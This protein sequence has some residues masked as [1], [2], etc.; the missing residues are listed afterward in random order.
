MAIKIIK[1][2]KEKHFYFQCLNCGT[3]F[4]Y[5]LKDVTYGESK[6]G[7]YKSVQCP[8][9][10]EYGYADLYRLKGLKIFKFLFL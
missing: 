1:S 3:E 4:A 2:G 6:N 7:I 8:E 5:M 10:K 9:C